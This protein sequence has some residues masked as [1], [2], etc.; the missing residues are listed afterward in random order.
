LEVLHIFF[1]AVIGVQILYFL[2]Y[3][4]GFSKAVT[5][6]PPQSLPVSV[7]VCAHDEEQNLRELIPLLLSQDHPEFEVIVVDDRSNDGTFDMLIQ[8]TSKDHRLR[9]VHVNRTP[10][11]FNAKKYALTLGI[12]AAKYEWLLLSDADCRPVS[13]NWI[14]SISRHFSPTT[15]FVLGFSPYQHRPGIL[16]AFIR[17]E[18]LITGMQYTS[19]AL[20]GMPYMGVGRNLSYRR[21][22]FLEA[23]GFNNFIKITGGDDDLFVNQN[24]RKTNT[25]VSI[26]ADAVVSSLPKQTLKSFFSQKVRHLSVGKY[27]RFGHRILLG[28]F[29]F[30]WIVTWFLGIPLLFFS[31]IP[32]VIAGLLVLRLII[33]VV[34]SKAAASKLHQRLE[35]WAVPLLDFIYAFYYLVAGIKALAT[36]KVRWKN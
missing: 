10:P 36:K 1:Y 23:K 16:N 35:I 7:I 34:T 28:L 13:K 21:T 22:R 32:Y 17:F 8:E 33:F 19:F 3:T 9:M 20:L 29:S 12:K 11:L 18:T 4:I 25:A 31:N 27:Y 6:K 14:S 15:H 24:A 5:Q 2:I 30:S 26:D